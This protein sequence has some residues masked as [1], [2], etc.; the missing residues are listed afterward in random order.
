MTQDNLIWIEQRIQIRGLSGKWAGIKLK[1]GKGDKQ[2]QRTGIW[3]PCARW[4][5]KLGEVRPILME[6]TVT[7]QVRSNCDLRLSYP[8]RELGHCNLIL[9]HFLPQKTDLVETAE[10]QGRHWFSYMYQ[11]FHL[12]S[13]PGLSLS[14]YLS[15][16]WMKE[17]LQGANF[18]GISPQYMMGRSWTNTLASLL[19]QPWSVFHAVS[20]RYPVGLS[21]N[22][23]QQ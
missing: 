17:I 16:S 6:K 2:H 13:K 23:P 18:P 3:E 4:T 12:L 9:H 10:N 8:P 11:C 15:C 19:G 5:E 20:Q 21:L 22:W 1:M 14:W 7:A